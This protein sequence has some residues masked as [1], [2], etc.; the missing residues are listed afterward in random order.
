VASRCGGGPRVAGRLA[1]ARAER[2]MVYRRCCLP[3]TATLL[4]SVQLCVIAELGMVVARQRN[5]GN[6]SLVP[7]V[8]F[9]GLLHL[10]VAGLA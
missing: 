3:C 1:W 7:V 6:V 4:D 9:A 8:L 5:A 10:C 2:S